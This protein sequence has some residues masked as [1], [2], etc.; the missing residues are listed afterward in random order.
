MSLQSKDIKR[1]ALTEVY[2]YIKTAHG[3]LTEAAHTELVGTFLANAF[4][5]L[6]PPSCTNGAD[7]DPEEDDPALEPAWAHLQ[8][9]MHACVHDALVLCCMAQCMM[10][11]CC[12]VHA[13]AH[14][15]ECSFN[16]LLSLARTALC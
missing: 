5:T 10:L 3:V 14:V 16:L 7:F 15:V 11:W 4:R 9:R 2:E 8:V 12:M 13:W 1:A 6:P